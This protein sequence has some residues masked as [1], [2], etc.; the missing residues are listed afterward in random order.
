M[1]FSKMNRK[2]RRTYVQN[3]NHRAVGNRKHTIG[4]SGRL[5][6]F[7]KEDRERIENLKNPVPV[8]NLF[9]KLKSEPIPENEKWLYSNK[10]A[11][12]SV[13]KGLEEAKNYNLKKE[14]E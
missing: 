7:E 10:K 5:S 12:D 14:A 3:I 8:S 9:N 11:L 13:N 2:D 6:Q 1:E 4:A